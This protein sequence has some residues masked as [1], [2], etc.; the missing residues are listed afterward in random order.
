MALPN[1]PQRD[2]FLTFI[3]L[4]LPKKKVKH[5]ISVTETLLEVLPAL[6]A[7]EE[8]AVTAGLLH[9]S[10]R[11]AT[12]EEL[13]KHANAYEIPMSRLFEEKPKLLHGPV[14][15]EY[16]RRELGVDDPEIYEAIFWHT[17]GHANFCKLGQGLYYADF[18][19]PLRDYP[20]AAEARAIQR[21]DGFEKALLFCAE[22]K[23]THVRKSA[24]LDPET[25]AFY[26]WLRQE[27]T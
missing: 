23:T 16:A 25:H 3:E 5:S 24:I 13:L 15:A 2:K 12:I 1:T 27:Y 8:Q 22:S 21:K 26:E 18:S 4:R 14:A 7:T 6:G 17:T 20:Q 11:G 9:D 19:E 10:F